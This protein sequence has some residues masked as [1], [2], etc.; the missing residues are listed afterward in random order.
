ME[1]SAM[2]VLC[3]FLLLFGS[4]QSS[5]SSSPIIAIDNEEA[6]LVQYARTI[7][8]KHKPWHMLFVGGSAKDNRPVYPLF[9]GYP[10][11]VCKDPERCV[12]PTSLNRRIF[13]VMILDD[14]NIETVKKNAQVLSRVGRQSRCLLVHKGVLRKGEIPLFFNRLMEQVPSLCEL[15]NF[16]K[17]I[18]RHRRTFLE[19]NCSLGIESSSVWRPGS[20]LSNADSWAF[21]IRDFNGCPVG[22]STMESMPSM[23][24]DVNPNGPI[25]IIGGHE[26]E[27]VLAIEKKLNCTMSLDRSS[28]V[29]SMQSI[30]KESLLK[31]V[32]SKV[33]DFI[34]GQFRPTV[35]L[36]ET[37]E[38]SKSYHQA[39]VTWGVSLNSNPTSNFISAEF[40]WQVWALIGIISVIGCV[41]NHVSYNKRGWFGEGKSTI[42]GK[43]I[44]TL[45]CFI[46][47][48]AIK[49]VSDLLQR[50]W[51]SLRLTWGSR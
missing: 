39:C 9:N 25:S 47:F 49:G 1:F 4:S 2:I 24:I 13:V 17:K 48:Q 16:D 45:R 31:A 30:T 26:G 19:N 21:E 42:W 32:G 33:A 34:I 12:H 20:D 46:S 37:F 5:L 6:F 18:V 28:I 40:S 10:Y 11:V 35:E 36:M 15:V 23:Q 29:G 38:Y 8:K 43:M 50:S 44:N 14:L 7:V 22:V 3:F 27:L 41:I 51:T